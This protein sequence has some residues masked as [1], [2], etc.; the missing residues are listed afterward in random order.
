MANR[1][2]S[3]SL[4]ILLALVLGLAL[5]WT[6]G[7]VTPVSAAPLPQG[8]SIASPSLVAPEDTGLFTATTAPPVGV[9]TLKWQAVVGADKY[10]VQ[11]SASAGFADPVV[12]AQTYAN[13]YTPEKALA[14]GTYYWR[15]RA[16]EDFDL[17]P[18]LSSAHLHQ[19]LERLRPYLPGATQ[20]AR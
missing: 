12:D 3:K 2:A 13:S 14:D 18:V 5:W 7:P 16:Q 10:N 8:D 17:G 1:I 9:P 20:S 4:L 11:V 6:V 15:V 19:R